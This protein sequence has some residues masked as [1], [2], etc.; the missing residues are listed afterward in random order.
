MSDQI[1]F[2]F[3]IEIIS[4]SY[5]YSKRTERL[6]KRSTKRIATILLSIMLIVTYMI[7]GSVFADSSFA[8]DGSDEVLAEEA[9]RATEEILSEDTEIPEI[10]DEEISDESSPDVS[11]EEPAEAAEE[12]PTEEPADTE[13]SAE[14]EPEAVS[15]EADTEVLEV[16]PEEETYSVEA[17]ADQ[18]AAGEDET[19]T[20]EEPK[21]DGAKAAGEQA[22][23]S[24]TQY[25]AFTSDIHNSSNNVAANRLD[26]WFDEIVEE[27]GQVDYMGFCGDMGAASANESQFWEYTNAVKKVVDD[28]SVHGFYTTGNHEYYNGKFKTTTNSVKDIYTI[29]AEDPYTSNATYRVY[30][31]GTTVD[32]GVSAGTTDILEQTQI[33]A[34]ISYMAQQDGTKPIIVLAHFPLHHF[35]SRTTSNANKVI[36]ALNNAVADGKTIV[37]LWGHN[38][39][40]SDTFYDEIYGPGDSIPYS[41]SGNATIQFY[42]AAAGC[43]SDY[44]YSGTGSQS[45]LGKGL[46]IQVRDDGHFDPEDLGFAFHNADGINVTE[47]KDEYPIV[48]APTPVTAFSINKTVE[49]VEVSRSIRITATVEPSNATSK[50][51]VWTSSNESVATV[52]SNGKVKGI[53]EGS[54]TITATLND[55]VSGETFTATCEVNVIPKTTQDTYYI[56]KIGDYV[57]S[58]IHSDDSY[59]SGGSSYY[60]SSST[61]NGMAAVAYSAA[62]KGDD[63]ISWIIE[64]AEDGNSYYIRN[65]DGQYLTATYETSGGSS[66]YGGSSTSDVKLSDTPEAWTL[67]SGVTLESWEVDGSKLMNSGTERYLT[68]E[69]G[70]NGT[71]LFTIRSSGEETII[72]DTDTLPS[73]TNATAITVSPKTLT[74][75]TG[76]SKNLTVTFTPAEATNKSVTWTS[77]NTSVATVSDSGK[78]T[79]IA[80]GTATITATYSDGVLTD[81]CEVT[82]TKA[83]GSGVTPETG[84][85]YVILASD[86]YALTSEGEE[87]GYSNGSGDQIYH[88]YGLAGEE[89]TVGDDVIPDRLLWTFTASGDGYYIQDQNGNYLNGTYGS[90]DEG[91]STGRLKLDNTPDVWIISGATSG[92]TVSAHILKSTNASATASSDKYLTHGN[93]ENGGDNTNIFTLRSEDNATSTTFYEYTDDGTYVPDPDDPTPVD[94]PTPVDGNTYKLVDQFTAGKDY[95]IVS[96][97][98]TGSAYALTN[99]GG[100]SS[101]ASMGR[102][103]VTIENGDVDGDGTADLYITSD[104]TDIVWTAAA[105]SSGFDLAN[106]SDYLEGK[107]GNV[108]IFNSHQYADR[109]WL[110]E[111]NQLKHTGGQN[112]YVVYYSDSSF[113]STYNSTSEKIYIYEKTEPVQGDDPVESVSLNKTETTLT[114][115]DTETLV[116][117]VLPATAADKSVTWTSSDDT[118]ATVDQTGKVT[119]VKEGTATITVTTTDGGKTATCAVTV[120]AAPVPTGARYEEVT[121]PEDGNEYIIAVTKDNGNVY[122][123]KNASSN[124]SAETLAVTAGDN[125]GPAYIITDDSSVVWEYSASSKYWVNDDDYL[126]PSSS[127]GIMTYSSGRAVSYENGKMYFESRDGT[128]YYISCEGG[129]FDTT[130]NEAEAATI[131]LFAKTDETVPSED[132]VESVSLNKSETTLVEDDTETLVATVSPATAADKSVTWTSS[133]ETVATVDQTGKVTAVKEGTATITV[134]TTDGGKTATCAVTVTPKP[135]ATKYVLTDK[136]EAGKDYLIV[137]DVAA[138]SR[139]LKNPG[140]SSDGVS[141]S[142]TN[143]KTTVEVVGGNTIETA[144]TDIV[145]TAT[146]NEGGVYLTNNGDYL[147]VYQRSLRVFDA[148]KQP[149]RYWTY[150]DNHLTHNGGGSPYYVSYGSG[151]FSSATDVY[152][153]YLFAKIEEGAHEH[154]WDEGTVTT[155]PTCTEPGVKTYTCSGCDETR[156]EEIE[157]LGHDYVDTVTA[158]TCTELGHTTHT[159]SRCGN[160]YVDTYVDALGHDFGEWTEVTAATCTA[161]GSETRECS[162]CDV[163]ETRAIEA[164][165][166]DIVHHAAKIATC[167]EVGWAAYDTCSRCDYTTYVEIPAAGHTNEAPVKENEV[168][169]TCTTQGSYDEVVY[170]GVCHEEVSRVTHTVEALGHDFGEWTQTKAPT[171]TEAGVETRECSRCDETETRAIEA[172]GHD[173]T[174]E[175]TAPTCTVRGY[176]THTCS[177]CGDS[178]IDTYVDALGHDWDEGEVTK[179]PTCSEAGEKTFNCSR[180]DATKTEAIEAIG[181]KWKYTGMSW[182][183][184]E[185]GGYTAKANY[186]CE[187]DA[188]HISSIDVEVIVEK[189]DATCTEAGRTVYTATIAADASAD[190]N[191]HDFGMSV[192]GQ[193]LGHDWG[194]GEIT[195]PA[196]CTEDGVRTFTCSRCGETR[197][198][199]IKATG[200]K[201][202]TDAA[203]A[204]TCTED[205]LTEGSH[206]ETCGEILVA[207][208]VIPAKGHKP[209]IDQAVAPTC[210]ETGLTEGKHCEVCDEVLVKQEIVPALGHTEVIDAA[211]APTCTE[212]GLTEGSHCS[213]CNEV[214]VAQEVIPATGHTEVT[215]AAVAPTCTET[216]LTE[217]SHCEV[218]N[219]VLVAQ[220]VI[221]AKGHTEVVDAAVEP[222]C[223][224]TGLTEGS[225]C[226]VCNEV[227][228][229]QEVVPALGHTEVTD[230]AVA[231]TCE[232]T[233]LTAGSHCSVC[234]EVLVAQ[235]IIPALGH[236]WGTVVYSWTKDYSKG[237]ATRVCAND[238]SHVDLETVDTTSAVTQEASCEEA[239]KTTY[240]AVFEN[241]DF[242]TQTITL[243]NIPALG[244]TEVTDAAVPATCTE[245]GLTEGSHCDVC[246]KVLVAQTV[247]PAKGHTEVTDE[248]VAP[249]CEE[250]GLTEGSH[251]SVCGEVLVAQEEIAALGHDWGTPVYGWSKD[252]KTVI[253]TR[254]CAHDSTHKETETV[255]TTSKVTK[256]ATCTAKGTRTYTAEFTNPA[257][258]TQTKNV[259][260]AATGHSYG[261]YKLTTKAGTTKSG[262]L[263]KT[264]S[265]CG[266]TSVMLVEPTIAKAVV[267]TTTKATISWKKVTGAQQYVIYF[268]DCGQDTV[269]KLTTTTSLSYV[270]TGLKNHTTYKFRVDAQRKIGGKWVTISTGYMGHFVAGDLTTSGTYTNVKSVSVKNAAVTIKKGK[271]SKITPSATLVKSGKTALNHVSKFRYI[272]TNTAVA[273]VASNGTI[274]AKAAGTCSIYVL[275]GNGVWKE[276][277]VT[278]TK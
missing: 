105:N 54:A 207:Q 246:G 52:D 179:A 110:Y 9:D 25:L 20:E 120:E 69:T 250:T 212:P 174:S 6:M 129:S 71:H 231:P 26:G 232:E 213:V 238:P 107:S 271:T 64:E 13:E 214:L 57:M 89:Y 103:A 12:E 91:G 195:T 117:T 275:A 229:A 274:T 82:V 262:K 7:P 182:T 53:S 157:A 93:G 88:Y 277:K 126:Y 74:V 175:V 151:T 56:I 154:T 183:E 191:A 51:V 55:S 50:K 39:T 144:D 259:S 109:P 247:V 181:H 242:E 161:V 27:Y 188:E 4:V 136:L 234:N 75:E 186:V 124:T 111:G 237:I 29:G 128:L 278:V 228:V 101:G 165:G 87:V 189:T 149:A 63:D 192:S 187:N 21:R 81:T 5:N 236:D 77:S 61:Y 60:G 70:S 241:E 66:W 86:G 127:Q 22:P 28:H 79:G 267:N 85:K 46:V 266:G 185:G 217:G 35:S 221:P 104:A 92:S 169:A 102:T 30:A 184:V 8:Q 45:V 72:E 58:T 40:L 138:S 142:A 230:E 11:E 203:V 206:C 115:G 258:E 164:L 160:S 113:T 23:S 254:T 255:T 180:C 223:T 130:T 145:W 215:D 239:G 276:V 84:K 159:C 193:P 177:R 222:T 49:T 18:I 249:T 248:A 209:V 211:K 15:E 106:G 226:E 257:F 178:N 263:T 260:I 163:T 243:A 150:S 194:E 17:S 100:T 73:A 152:T 197:T 68:E 146:A 168:A 114:E 67:D 97:N 198:E 158:P 240:T 245:D 196:T 131:R 119:A 251:C 80:K 156:T 252:N 83:A 32:W 233:G 143:G 14:E 190:G 220:E 256:K 62:T 90:N 176:T 155:E 216:G 96:A 132:P 148:A 36:D 268:A 134:T 78:V 264:C 48:L 172:L 76:S 139:A 24:G 10:F 170:C 122:A 38:H 133:D 210:T 65:L 269:K 171:C 273:T 118:V 94:P 2:L 123:I 201:P 99:P 261:E 162:R 205:G 31:L 42:Y 265:A 235:E 125:D 98:A 108:K 33:D 270:K 219:E 135:E 202:V 227:L 95:L 244:H 41:S 1:V 121:S 16:V 44:E 173:Y 166:H 43:M 112:T 272:S 141:I 140:G 59:S 167:T 3:D 225:H 153:I 19:A 34:L 37:Y 208:E 137:N 218:C 253:A 116:A 147:E 200:H 199:T 47:N 224:E 204:E